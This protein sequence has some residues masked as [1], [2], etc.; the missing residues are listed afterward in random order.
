MSTAPTPSTPTCQ[1]ALDGQQDGAHVIQRR[2]LLLQDV[3]ADVALSVHVGVVTG[4]EEAHRGCGVGISAGELQGQF[5]AQLLVGLRAAVSGVG[6]R[7]GGRGGGARRAVPRGVSPCPPRRRWCRSSGRG[8]RTRGRRRCLCRR[9]S[10]RQRHQRRP[11]PHRPSAPGPTHHQRHQ[12]LL[13]PAGTTRYGSHRQQRAG[14]P[15]GLR[16]PARPHLFPTEPRAAVAPASAPLRAA[17]L[18]TAAGSVF[19]EAMTVPGRSLVLSLGGLLGWTRFGP[20]PVRLSSDPGSRPRFP[21]LP[22]RPRSRTPF[23]CF[24]LATPPP[25]SAHFRSRQPIEHSQERGCYGNGGWTRKRR[26]SACAKDPRPPP[27]SQ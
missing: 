10:A 16:P 23:E 19:C 21:C 9:T 18:G 1:Q 25:I 8:Y 22:F 5:I 3:E 6:D 24:K 2:P 4:R 11:G 26:D 20:L 15:N 17:A 12:L 7:E 14:Q 27:G 13:Q